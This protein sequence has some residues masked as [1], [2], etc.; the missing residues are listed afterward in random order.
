MDPKPIATAPDPETVEAGPQSQ[1]SEPRAHR[2]SLLVFARDEIRVAELSDGDS[3]VVGRSAPADVQIDDPKLS[4]HHARFSRKGDLVTVED[5]GSRNGTWLD[6]QRVENARLTSG[7]SILIGSCQAAVHLASV[8]SATVSGIESYDRWLARLDDE[9]ARARGFRRP[10]SV[11][12]VRVRSP[13]ATSIPELCLQLRAQLRSVDVIGIYGS[14]AI[15]ILAPEMSAA[16][17]QTL[18]LTLSASSRPGE[19]NTVG[20]ATFPDQAASAQELLSE[21]MQACLRATPSEPVVSQPTRSAAVSGAQG[22]YASPKMQEACLLLR[23]LATRNLPVLILGETGT[24][25]ELAARM[26]HEEGPRRDAPMR[27]VNCGAIPENLVTSVL[28]GHERGA[29]T[30][31]D[32]AR[33]GVFEDAEDGTVFLDEVGELSAAAQ[34]ALLRVLETRKVVRVGGNREL[35]IRARFVAATHRD[36]DELAKTG[37]FRLDLLHRLNAVTVA[38]PPLRERREDIP[39]LVNYF[40]EQGN[41]EWETSA[42][43]LAPETLAALESY[44]W[45]GNVR[46]LRNV[47]ARAIALSDGDTLS[48]QEL[49]ESIRGSATQGGASRPTVAPLSP[50]LDLRAHLKQVERDLMLGALERAGGNQR[51]AAE[52]L[53]IPL[54]TFERR[55]SAVKDADSE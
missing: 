55:L 39:L 11:L 6:G 15:L 53:G 50:G 48:V 23:R 9:I 49:P 43:H 5:L 1:G 29:F 30:G 22:V 35:D 28:F 31:A 33:P 4:R 36:L 16:A 40:L 44:R 17:A 2:V 3:L 45:P 14:G 21:A 37:A 27:V 32:R 13:K 19:L 10:L 47:L 8:L 26:L 51:R 20:I 38:L 25:K 52:L 54:R 24:G 46:E 12:M 42:E 7:A 34:A 41:R 18:A